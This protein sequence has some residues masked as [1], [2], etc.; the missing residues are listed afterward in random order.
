MNGN[1]VGIISAVLDAKTTYNLSGSLP[2]NV[3]YAIKSSYAKAFL[4]AVPDIQ[5]KM[6]PP[7]QQP[8]EKVV[9]RA[10]KSVVMVVSY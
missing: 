2:Q 4:S 6:P 9:D 10:M 7:F 1:V 5:K 8:S 3:N